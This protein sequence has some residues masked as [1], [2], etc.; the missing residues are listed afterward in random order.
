MTVVV[1]DRK[2][3]SLGVQNDTYSMNER[4]TTAT[5]I[6]V[7][8]KTQL[9]KSI[10]QNH[11]SYVRTSCRNASCCRKNPVKACHILYVSRGSLLIPGY[12]KQSSIHAHILFPAETIDQPDY[13]FH[14]H[15]IQ[16]QAGLT[17]FLQWKTIHQPDDA[18]N[19][20]ANQNQA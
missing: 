6:A 1:R 20:L 12:K 3:K 5:K 11:H 8:P 15:A 9:D 4:F 7:Q 19:L 14:L 10:H 18:F 16:N 13:T 2:N 17:G